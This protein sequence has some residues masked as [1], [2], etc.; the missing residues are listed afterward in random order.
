MDETLQQKF[1][2]IIGNSY[3]NYG[4]SP[5]CGWIEALLGLEENGL[6]QLD[7][8]YQLSK[9]MRNEKTGTSLSSVNRALKILRSYGSIIRSG[10]AKEGYK[11]KL[12]TN[13]E[14]FDIF[15]QTFININKKTLNSLKKLKQSAI[16]IRNN[17]L[18]KAINNELLYLEF[19]DMY[20]KE[21][22]NLLKDFKSKI[23]L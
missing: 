13:P 6:S 7:I 14:F 10:S 1:L 17:Q 23:N 9:I 16:T 18:I 8:S 5:L 4:F 15:I 12:N 20:F 3:K 22:R 11:Y 2:K 19:I 21:S